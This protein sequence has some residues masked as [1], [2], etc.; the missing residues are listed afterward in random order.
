MKVTFNLQGTGA[1]NNG[2]TATLF[3]TANVLHKL[4]HKVFVVSDKLNY[5]TWFDLKGP[6]YIKCGTPE[7]PD[8]DILLATG[9]SSIKH[10]LRAKD[11]KGVKHWWVR[12][13]ETWIADENYIFGCYKN[14]SL[15]IMVNS[16]CLQMFL[17]KKMGKTFPIVRPGTDV[18]FF[19]EVK[20]R[21]W[22]DKKSWVLG[23]LYNE[24]P[25]KRFKWVPEIY[26]GLKELGVKCRLHLFGDSERP[27]KI[28]EHSKYLQQP[29]PEDL[30][31]FYNGVDLWLAP[32]KSEGLHM[33]PQEAM[34]CGAVLFGAN[35]TLSGMV[36][37]LDDNK[38][39]I[40]VKDWPDAVQKIADLV[41]TDDGRLMLEYMS[42]NGRKR[43]VEMGD[44]R[45]NVKKMVAI[46]QSGLSGH[47]SK[48]RALLS[49]GIRV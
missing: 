29:S 20:P 11:S 46:F 37:Y 18:D 19:K 3:H 36:D 16:L 2:G 7:Y 34:L 22:I 44:R 39:G 23:A 8:A 49:R 48:M 6:E 4:G 17:K 12:A 10:V 41:A 24:K 21:K 40:V 45:F 38:T 32:T 15:N 33:P 5:F 43:I 30:L 26:M 35:E 25:R 14:R 1:A 28:V 27:K 42:G 31:K 9:V 13:H 47:H